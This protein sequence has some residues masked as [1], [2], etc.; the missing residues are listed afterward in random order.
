MKSMG[1]DTNK[2]ILDKTIAEVDLDKS[3]DI[4]WVTF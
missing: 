3:G 2:E 1:L 4:S